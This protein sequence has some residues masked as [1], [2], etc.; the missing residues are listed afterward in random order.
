[1][2]KGIFEFEID[3]KKRG[4]KFGTYGLGVACEKEKCSI[5]VLYRRIGQPYIV[6]KIVDG[7]EEKEV[8]VDTVKLLSLL[9]VFYG[10]AVHYADHTGTEI[11]FRPSDVS[12]WL[13]VIGLDKVNGILKE[14]LEQYV[15]KNS[16]SLAVEKGETVT[17]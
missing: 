6:T 9:H 13:D 11:D 16:T 3:G 8:K 2:K 4:L 7:K 15:P 12:D 14:G 5:D 10:A 1:M 17:A